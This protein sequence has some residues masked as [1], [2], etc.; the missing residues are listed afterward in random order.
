MGNKKDPTF[1]IH[2]Q[3]PMIEL[4]HIIQSMKSSKA[5]HNVNGV[6]D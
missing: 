3:K 5:E 4:Y 2:W 1:L 6:N